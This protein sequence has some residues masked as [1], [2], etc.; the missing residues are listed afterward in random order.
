MYAPDLKG[1]GENKDMPYPYS[2]DDYVNEV[3]EYINKNSIVCPFVIAHSFGARIVLKGL[4]DKKFN[5]SKVVITGGAGLKPKFRLKKTIKKAQ[6]NFLKR[7]VDKSK[8]TRFYSPDYLALGDI[9][10]KSFTLIV[11]EKLDYTLK[12]IDNS[13][14]LAFGKYDKETPLY[15]A[16]RFNKGLKNSTLSVYNN[17][18]HFC[19]ITEKEK[20][21]LEVREFLLS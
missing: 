21:N 16:K 15:M 3:S 12:N 14:L 19:F 5:F 10:K 18:G 17:S 20:F 9:M 7:F 4:S 8:L 1:F 6:F 2:L 13:V 11:N